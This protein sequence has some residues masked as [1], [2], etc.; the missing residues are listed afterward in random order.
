MEYILKSAFLLVL[1][2]VGYTLFL[3]KE[4]FF[5]H[6][7]WFLL[8]GLVA[9]FIL[10]L[11]YIPQYIQVEKT[12]VVELSVT[13]NYIPTEI[14]TQEPTFDWLQLLTVLYIIGAA[15]FFVQFLFQFGSLVYLLLKNAKN[16]DGI[17]TYVIVKNK[18]SPFSFFKWIVYN[19]KL[20]NDEELGLILNHE[21]VHVRQWHSLDIILSQ[22]TC[23]I[24]WFNPIVWFYHKNIE[25][26]LEY[27]ADD[28]AQTLSNSEKNYQHLLLKTSVGS[29]NINLTS[30]FYNSLIKKRIVML[31]KNR[32]KSI[33]KW[34][35]ILV[36]PLIALFLMSV[37]RKEI[38]E[39]IEQPIIETPVSKETVEILFYATTTDAEFQSIKN[40]LKSHDISMDLKKVKRN[41]DGK[42]IAIHVEFKNTK[43]NNSTSYMEDDT[44][45]ISPFYYKCSED[46]SM[47]VG[48]VDIIEVVEEVS[49]EDELEEESEEV[50]DI[51]IERPS[52]DKRKENKFIIKKGEKTKI[53]ARGN[54]VGKIENGTNTIK[55]DSVYFIRS[56][57]DKEPIYIVNGKRI[58]KEDFKGLDPNKI[59]KINVLKDKSAVTIYGNDGKNGVV[60][61]ITKDGKGKNTWTYKTADSTVIVA[62][63][64][65]N[66][67]QVSKIEGK[68]YKLPE[69]TEAEVNTLISS[70]KEPLIIV[71]NDILGK[72]DIKGLDNSII[73]SM[74]VVKGDNAIKLYGEKAKDGAIII[75]TKDMKGQLKQMIDDPNVKVQVGSIRFDDDNDNT[76][77]VLHYITKDTPDNLMKTHKSEL[78]SNGITVKYSKLKR[79]KEGKI[80]RLKVSLSDKEGN[81]ASATYENQKGIPKIAIGKKN[82]S[83]IASSS[84]SF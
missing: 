54:V 58:K 5:N 42:I 56:T 49:E 48:T 82:G 55:A 73:E 25:Q 84:Y 46:G 10:P 20:F 16:K 68:A 24:F 50:D 80:V 35:S 75:I 57:N 60:E 14:V 63:K 59:D 30:N 18:I 76:T 51:I 4:T 40:K 34:K 83:L 19:P 39:Y 61:I 79:N 9:S 3:K 45:G 28:E 36:I 66:K 1:L 52:S 22:L 47:S 6:N 37:N 67:W 70:G 74:S 27:I 69:S 23:V 11:I 7:R 64:G 17:Y 41:S 62:K 72:V 65:D 26:N 77:M 53:I 78:A 13:Y 33:N 29:N 8:S 32:S 31:Q 81:K 21:R 15:I 44:D 71:N 12:P 38:Y 43:T 2:H